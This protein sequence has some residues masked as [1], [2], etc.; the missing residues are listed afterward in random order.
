MTGTQPATSRHSRR[1]AAISFPPPQR[2]GKPWDI[3]Q[4]FMSCPFS[5]RAHLYGIKGQGSKEGTCYPAIGTIAPS[6]AGSGA[7]GLIEKEQRW[8]DND[9]RSSLYY[10]LKGRPRPQGKGGLWLK[11]IFNYKISINK[12]TNITKMLKKHKNIFHLL[13][14]RY[15]VKI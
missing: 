7:G 3:L 1:S 10:T 13:I 4:R 15:I 11:N 14:K 12:F 9:G 6:P 8:Q 2:L 5:H